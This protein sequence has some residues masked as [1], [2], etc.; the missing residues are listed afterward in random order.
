MTLFLLTL[1]VVGIA[2]LA[3]AVGSLVGRRPLAGG[4]HRAGLALGAGIGCGI[5]GVEGQDGT[6]NGP[7][8]RE[9]P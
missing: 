4:C 1:V 8:R 2:I 5:C 6:P 9:F 3:M 7:E